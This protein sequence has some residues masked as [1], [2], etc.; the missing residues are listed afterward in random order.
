MIKLT[1]LAKIYQS[2]EVETKALENVNININQ[3]EFISIMGPSGSGKTTLLNI[4]GLLDQPTS[5]E[6]YFM[7]QNV[8]TRTERQL[9]LLR[10]TNI[11][12]I[13]QSFNLIEELT[14]FK[15]VELPLRYLKMKS[16]QLLEN[17]VLEKLS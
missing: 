11:G 2:D 9:A 4:L 14:V 3:G 17:P 10:K 7:E 8:T 15:N 6:V 16:L 12:F 1:N 5:G 13:F